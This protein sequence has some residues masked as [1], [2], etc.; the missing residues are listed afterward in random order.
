MQIT[1]IPLDLLDDAPINANVLPDSKFREL[2]A[3]IARIGFAVPIV[4]RDKGDGRFE[5]IDGHHRVRAM[6]EMG[7]TH[8]PGV[9][10]EEGEDPRTVA[11][12][13]NRLRG[14][15]DLAIASR[16]LA[17]MMEDGIIV[18]DLS[19]TGF[20]ERELA[21]LVASVTDVEPTLDDLANAELP[22]PVGE[23][24]ARP[25]LLELTFRDKDALKEVR[26]ALKKAAGKGNDMADGLLRVVRGE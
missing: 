21:E 25:F 24:A 12:A 16:M 11:L 9:L 19:I 14:E 10:L 6:R 17:E 15:T 4:A 5:I 13:L 2:K 8:I 20:T 22:E 1:S 7:E 26:K 23:P 18:E 3:S